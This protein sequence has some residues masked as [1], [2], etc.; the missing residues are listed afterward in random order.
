LLSS[1]KNGAAR[2]I[3]MPT[4]YLLFTISISLTILSL[5]SCGR[6]NQVSVLDDNGKL[7]AKYS[8][9]EDSV[10][11]GAYEAYLDGV[12]YEKANYKS[13]KLNGERQLF[14]PSGK[15]E[16]SETYSDN[17]I[18][19]VYKSFFESGQLA[20][21]AHY[22]NGSM[23]GILKTYY[24]DG[25]L[26]D[27]VSMKNNEENG[28]FKEYYKSGKLKWEG[29]FLNGDN[30]FGLIK[31]YNEEGVLVKKMTC[32]SLAVCTTIW[33]LEKGDITPKNN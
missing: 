3:F 21:E 28:P 1:I 13:G 4:K 2:L 9:N 33:T 26:K 27:M 7:S 30:E 32:D 29:N 6:N 22:I 10:K 25:T 17:V 5:L 15:V 14:Y 16:I 23:E 19:G 24:K 8:I 12:L 31:N 18:T 20:Q 11:H